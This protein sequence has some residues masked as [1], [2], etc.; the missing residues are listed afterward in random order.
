M[1]ATKQQPQLPDLFGKVTPPAVVPDK[2][3][4]RRAP[5]KVRVL[6]VFHGGRFQAFTAPEVCQKFPEEN[7]AVVTAIIMR[8]VRLNEIRGTGEYRN[9]S[10]CLIKT[11]KR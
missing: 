9:G 2:T 5:L 8:L 10:L 1:S 7:P 3:V 4:A 6:D 11:F